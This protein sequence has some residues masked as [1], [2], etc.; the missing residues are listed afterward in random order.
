MNSRISR[1]NRDNLPKSL[2]LVTSGTQSQK[3]SGR[4]LVNSPITPSPSLPLL[5]RRRGCGCAPCRTWPS[6][7]LGWSTK[8]RTDLVSQ[9]A[10]FAQSPLLSE[11][12]PKTP[13]PYIPPTGCMLN[14]DLPLI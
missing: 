13:Q 5:G 3:V 6:W 2:S 4:C 9:Y 8:T 1:I 11:H 10:A 12:H 7:V 14:G